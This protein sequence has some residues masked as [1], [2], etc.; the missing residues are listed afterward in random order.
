ML[1]ATVGAVLV[2]GQQSPSTP[3]RIV[4]DLHPFVSQLRPEDRHVILDYA[5]APPLVVGGPSEGESRLE[6]LAKRSDVIVVVRVEKI[7]SQLVY[8]DLLR[9]ER[10][11]SAEQANWIV[12]TAEA[13]LESVVKGADELG[14]ALGDRV[15]LKAEGGTAMIG[16]TLV[17]AVVS[18][19]SAMV[20]GGRYLLFGHMFDGEF[21][22]DY[23]YAE[24]SRGILMAMRRAAPAAPGFAR[25]PDDLEYWSLD[26]ALPLIRNAVQ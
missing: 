9:N 6:W 22:R 16:G 19:E 8:R 20:S 24:S 13:R 17:E 25:K 4:R 2:I 1:A 5:Q 15:Y 7:D 26:Q 11:V 3:R 18:W 12:S 10:V 21:R 14:R 23:A